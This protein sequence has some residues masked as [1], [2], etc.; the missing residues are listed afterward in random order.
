MFPLPKSLEPSQKKI[1][2]RHFYPATCHPSSFSTER[3]WSSYIGVQMVR[4]G[5][6][7]DNVN[8]EEGEEAAD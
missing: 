6:Y 2:S 7:Y 5:F 1:S 3:K 8:G 4:E